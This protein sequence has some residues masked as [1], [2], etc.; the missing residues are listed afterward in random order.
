[1][2]DKEKQALLDS[3]DKRIA[4]LNIILQTDAG[5][6]VAK[7]NQ[8]PEQSEKPHAIGEADVE[9][10]LLE[11]ARQELAQLKINKEWLKREEG[12]LC[13]HCDEYIPLQR[14]MAVPTTRSCV[15]CA[16]NENKR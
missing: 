12:G 3:I 15:K 7:N 14:L 13:V 9:G 5:N 8:E 1:M 11:I 6:A 2:H 4:R 10:A 16:E